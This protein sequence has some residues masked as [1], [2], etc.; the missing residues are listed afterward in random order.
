MKNGKTI[1]T[2]NGDKKY[3]IAI[4][5]LNTPHIKEPKKYTNPMYMKVKLI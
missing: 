5:Q 3:R 1:Y 4:L 2:S